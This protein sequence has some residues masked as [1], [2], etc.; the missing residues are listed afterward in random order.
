MGTNQWPQYFLAGCITVGSGLDSAGPT[1]LV[2]DLHVVD[3]D[4]SVD[5]RAG[6]CLAC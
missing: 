3:L 2:A 6:D 5:D 1:P 4:R